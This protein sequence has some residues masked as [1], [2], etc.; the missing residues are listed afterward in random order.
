VTRG[1][2]LCGVLPR[3]ELHAPVAGTGCRSG[4]IGHGP[5]RALNGD[6][7]RPVGLLT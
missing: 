6:G 5:D 4:T 2:S 7:A 3:P 1:H